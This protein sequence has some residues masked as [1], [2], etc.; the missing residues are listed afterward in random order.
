MKVLVFCAHADDEVIGAGGRVWTHWRAS[1]F[2]GRWA[3]K[4]YDNHGR[5]N[6]R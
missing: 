6:E 2:A 4:T 3:A 1:V 5:S